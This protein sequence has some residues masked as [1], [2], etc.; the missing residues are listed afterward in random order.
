MDRT[1]LIARI[2]ETGN[3]TKKL[4][5]DIVDNVT[6]VNV[7]GYQITSTA[8]LLLTANTTMLC[9]LLTLLRG[10]SGCGGSR[11]RMS[12]KYLYPRSDDYFLQSH[13]TR[14]SRQSWF[15]FRFPSPFQSL[16]RS[17]EILQW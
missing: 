11:A 7:F 14:P 9:G 4:A 13:H 10:Q 1:G 3:C 6:R 12:P 16:P 15:C 5:E 2:A 8:L 17:K